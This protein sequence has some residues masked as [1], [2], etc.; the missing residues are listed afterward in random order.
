MRKHFCASSFDRDYCALSV[1]PASGN[2]D[3]FMQKEIF[4]QPE[5]ILN[6]MRGRVN[7]NDLTVTL[8]GL[9]NHLVDIMRSRRLIFIGCG[10][11]YNS[12][13]AVGC[14]FKLRCDNIV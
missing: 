5:S 8:G 12:V 9:K 7:F 3:Y 1:L 13:I 6:T 14:S 10:T 2:Y 11:S 4:E